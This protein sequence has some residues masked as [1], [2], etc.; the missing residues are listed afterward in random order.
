MK[1]KILSYFNLNDTAQR[2]HNFYQHQEI[3]PEVWVGV[4]KE[5]LEK[6]DLEEPEI[7]YDTEPEIEKWKESDFDYKRDPNFVYR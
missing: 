7:I 5:E 3:R 4:T 1:K 2:V 6:D